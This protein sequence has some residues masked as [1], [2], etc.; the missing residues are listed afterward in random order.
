VEIKSAVF[1]RASTTAADA[2]VLK[3]P[4]IAICGRSNVGKS[5]LIN[6]LCNRKALARTS[7]TPGRTQ[8]IVLFRLNDSF[9]LADLPGFGYAKVPA[10]MRVEWGHQIELYIE[11]CPYLRGVLVLFDSR[12]ES[13]K[14]DAGLM[15]WLSRSG[16]PVI[17]ILTKFDKIS[18][19]DRFQRL[20]LARAVLEP[21]A[22]H[23]LIAT[24]SDAGEGREAVLAAIE[25]C[26]N[27]TLKKSME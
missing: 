24:S 6:Y 9:H 3:L 15:E 13:S 22:S 8:Q 18:K 16:R 19:T 10:E 25:S 26:L 7:R 11:T 21:N 1:E 20:K 4:Q 23:P 5:S 27:G 12:R 17:P 2:A 14:D